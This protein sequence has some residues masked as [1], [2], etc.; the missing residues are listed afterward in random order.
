MLTIIIGICLVAA[1]IAIGNKK[2]GKWWIC[3]SLLVTGTI[4]IA[5]GIAAP[6]NG[7]NEYVAIDEVRLSP[8][9]LNKENNTDIYIIQLENEDKIYKSINAENEEKIEIYNK[10]IKLEIIEQEKCEIPMLVHY[11]RPVKKSIFSLGMNSLGEKYVF[12][13]PKRSVIK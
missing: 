4:V 5:V 3:F 12:Y 1:A 13:V 10:S 2:I 7:Y 8:I 11:L 9:G 6:I